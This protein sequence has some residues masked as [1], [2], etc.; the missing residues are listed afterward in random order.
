MAW[1]EKQALRFTASVAPG[2]RMGNQEWDQFGGVCGHQH[3]PENTHWDPGALDWAAVVVQEDETT[4]TQVRIE[5]AAFWAECRGEWVE[6][7]LTET[8]QDRL[9]RMTDEV[10][11]GAL[12]L[13]PGSLCRVPPSLSTHRL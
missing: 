2:F 9:T 10:I 7:T 12:T 4:V 1:P 13:D 6:A 5:L 8:S 3:V 11:S